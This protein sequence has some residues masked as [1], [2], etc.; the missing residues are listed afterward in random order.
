M[1]DEALR[2][3]LFDYLLRLGDTSLILGH[4][5]S[6]W[7]G[8]A[9]EIEEDV[10]LANVAL[11]LV[12]HARMLLDYAGR[13]EGRGR[14]E[15][16]L[17]YHR[18]ILDY[19]NHLLVEQP[20]RDFGHTMARQFLHDAWAVG[21][22]EALTRSA[23]VELAGI[24]AKAVKEVRYHLRHSGDWVIRLGDG[25]D[26]SHAI[27]IDAFARLWRFTDEMFEADAVERDLAVAKIVPDPEMLRAGW[28]ARVDAVLSEATL[29]R[30]GNAGRQSGG[31]TGT[32]TEHLGYILADMQFLQRAYP[33]AAW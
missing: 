4:R 33:G 7:C 9:P 30:P 6:E 27:M 13:V 8:H 21:L 11:D 10:A 22:Y 1:L 24:A 17:A 28:D 18:D 14:D 29:S 12:G 15:D 2:A 19:R 32:H 3:P 20:N 26:A 31:R 23:D 16:G 25:T 5:V